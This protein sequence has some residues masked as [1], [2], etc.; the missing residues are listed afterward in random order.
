MSIQNIIWA[1]SRENIRS[2]KA[3]PQSLILGAGGGGGGG[4]FGVILVRLCE[5]VFFKPTPIIYLVF[6]TNDLFIYLLEH[7]HLLFFD[8]YIPSL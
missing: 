2:S 5:P 3:H 4:N 8:F 7:F 1:T 6:E